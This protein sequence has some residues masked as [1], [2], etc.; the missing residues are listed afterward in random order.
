M[1]TESDEAKARND[2]ER[3][4]TEN[5]LKQQQR[6]AELA[7]LREQQ[8]AAKKQN[9]MS[10]EQPPAT[11]ETW[12]PATQQD[13]PGLM[14][15]VAGKLAIGSAGDAELAQRLLN[16][17]QAPAGG[18]STAAAEQADGAKA[19]ITGALGVRGVTPVVER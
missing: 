4:K 6:D 16:S 15:T 13:S 10:A 5:L 9:N 3:V 19:R 8:E 1:G 7:K 18:R 17:G 11:G 2:L 14:S 12:S